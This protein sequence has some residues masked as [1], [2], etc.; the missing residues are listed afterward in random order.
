VPGGSAAW[1]AISADGVYT[2]PPILPSLAGVTITATSAAD[3]ARTASAGVTVLSDI[4]VTVS[5]V[6]PGIELGARQAFQAGVISSGRPSA[7]VLWSLSGPG[8][9]GAGCGTVSAD[10]TV[11]A[12]RVLPSPSSGIVTATS[13]A[14]PSKQ[15]A[16]IFNVTS[17]F[18]LFLT[19]PSNLFTGASA[20]YSS[21]LFPAANSDPVTTILWSLSG[22]GCT[23]TGCGTL[24]VAPSGDAARYTAPDAGTPPGPI[25]ITATPLADAAKAVTLD[26]TLRAP[27]VAVDDA[28][29]AVVAAAISGWT[30]SDPGPPVFDG[31]YCIERL[32]TLPGQSYRIYAEPLDGPLTAADAFGQVTLCRNQITD[33]GWP[34]RLACVT[35]RAQAGFSTRIRAGP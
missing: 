21:T 8:C 22:N 34:P 29:G 25:H 9:F 5:P 19:G 6:N 32:T 3:G 15:A 16:V 1:G 11:T 18:S 17:T 7:N 24:S 31:T 20:D 28:T 26:V 10:G 23:G 14:D 30:C 12:P 27:V 33:P 4:S 35:P 13:V 2:A